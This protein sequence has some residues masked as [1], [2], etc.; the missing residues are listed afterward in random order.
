MR[1]IFVA[2]TV[3]AYGAI[4][5][6]GEEAPAVDP[7]AEDATVDETSTD[8]AA[9]EGAPVD[10]PEVDPMPAVD[11]PAEEPAPV[12]EKTAEVTTEHVPEE[13]KFREGADGEKELIFK[14]DINEPEICHDPESEPATKAREGAQE[15]VEDEYRRKAITDDEQVRQHAIKKEHE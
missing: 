9:E 15:A 4:A 12:E 11:P 14:I 6:E 5:Q 10:G 3:L 2:F 7:P 8:P 13:E 1:K